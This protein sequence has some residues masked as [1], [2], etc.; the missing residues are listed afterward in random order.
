M[1]Q[2]LK[3]GVHFILEKLVCSIHQGKIMVMTI[4]HM[5]T[6]T[7]IDENSENVSLQYTANIIKNMGEK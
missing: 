4:N 3:A 7:P 2:Y 1:V 5:H 6:H